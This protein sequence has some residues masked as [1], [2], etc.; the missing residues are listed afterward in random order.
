MD[1]IVKEEEKFYLIKVQI[2]EKEMAVTTKANLFDTTVM[3]KNN[4]EQIN[5]LKANNDRLLREI[6]E[7]QG[8]EI[9]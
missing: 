4:K 7:Q 2:R 6:K 1:K 9:K 3:L 8:K 5:K